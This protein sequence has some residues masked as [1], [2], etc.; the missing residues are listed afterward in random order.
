MYQGG[1]LQPAGNRFIQNQPP[2][3]NIANNSNYRIYYYYNALAP[4]ED[5]FYVTG[6]VIKS[7]VSI[8]SECSGRGGRGFNNALAQYDEWNM[9]YESWLTKLLATEVGSEEYHIIL[10]E[11]SYYSALKDNYF[12]SIVVAAMND[13]EK[14]ENLRYL[15]SYRGNYTDHLSIVETY[16][17]E[18]RYEEALATLATMYHQFEISEE[19]ILELQGMAT[20]INWL[21]RLEA[22]ENT[23]YSLSD[24]EIEYLVNYVET[25]TGRGTVFAKNILCVL[26]DICLEDEN[27]I[28]TDPKDQT[29]EPTVTTPLPINN[30]ELLDRISVTPNPTTGELRVESGALRVESVDVFDVFGRNVSR[31]TSH[32]SHPLSIDLSHLPSG[33]YFVRITTETGTVV[34]KVVKQ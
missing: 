25:N 24:N 13:G 30:S 27:P 19:Q 18:S 1:A 14:G 4:E 3:V 6:Q 10:G 33:I 34:R 16:L 5:P 2:S 29:E 7:P 23:I 26:Y 9:E 12:N 22:E 32:I 17:A 31:L 21:Q 15:F 11:V 8:S 28:P 20:Y